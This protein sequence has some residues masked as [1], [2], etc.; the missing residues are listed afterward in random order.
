MSRKKRSNTPQVEPQAFTVEPLAVDTPTPLPV[1]KD[2]KRSLADNMKLA[3]ELKELFAA[4]ILVNEGSELVLKRGAQRAA[5]N[6][7]NYDS[8]EGVT[9]ALQGLGF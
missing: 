7:D 1:T 4:E 9:E 3:N 5:V 2:T 8:V 6:L